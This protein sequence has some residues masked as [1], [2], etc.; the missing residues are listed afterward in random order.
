MQILL[1]NLNAML[2]G[3]AILLVLLSMQLRVTDVNVQQ[4]ATYMTKKHSLDFADWL[5]DD[6]L[7]IGENMEEGEKAFENPSE[8]GD[9]TMEFVFYRDTLDYSGAVVDTVHIATRYR[10][11]Y[12]DTRTVEDRSVKVYQAHRGMQM[13]NPPGEARPSTWATTGHSAPLISGFQIKML[14]KDGDEVANPA[15]VDQAN[16]DSIQQT[17]AKFSMLPPIQNGDGSLRAMH[18]GANL[19]LR[20]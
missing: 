2:I 13:W 5:E 7:S 4:T 14:N 10:L 1:D 9:R 20:Y 16:P 3:G 12:V 19:L 17:K 6:L 15:D 11:T 8:S 18:W